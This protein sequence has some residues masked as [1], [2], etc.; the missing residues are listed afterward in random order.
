[1][2]VLFKSIIPAYMLLAL[3]AVSAY[4]Q[5]PSADLKAKIDAVVSE[6]YQAAAANFPCKLKAR[7]RAKMLRWQDVEKCLN[8]ANDRVDWEALSLELQKIRENGRYQATDISSAVESSLSAHAIPY[9]RVF[10]VKE[11]KALLPLSNSLL[12]F[13]PADSLMDLPVYDKSGTRMGTFSGVYSFEKVGEISGVKNRYSLFQ[14]TDLRGRMQA[15]P[16]RLLL[17]SFGVPWEGA[18]SQ[19]GFR[20]PSDRLLLRR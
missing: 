6:A 2:Q 15:A 9:D 8:N 13:L 14:Y 1:M 10:L 12:K 11:K 5:N 18:I 19:P 4:S 16:D 3:P 7:G 20:L 17:D